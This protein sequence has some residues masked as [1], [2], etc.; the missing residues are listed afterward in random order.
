MEVNDLFFVLPLTVLMLTC[1]SSL[2]PFLLKYFNPKL[3]LL[4]GG[5][6]TLGSFLG[7]SFVTNEILFIFLFGIFPGIGCGI[8]YLIPIACIWEY[9]P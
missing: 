8:C 5:F 3:I 4:V 9:F 7:A 1:F 2:G 6:L